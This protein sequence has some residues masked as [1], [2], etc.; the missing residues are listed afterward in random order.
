MARTRNG[1]SYIQK[2]QSIPPSWQPKTGDVIYLGGRRAKIKRIGIDGGKPYVW[3]K[4]PVD[5]TVAMS[6]AN[7]RQAGR[8]ESRTNPAIPSHWVPVS[9]TRKGK[10]IQIRTRGR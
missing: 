9:I 3:F 6:V 10:Q 5:G 7:L 8:I 2:G 4:R 1:R